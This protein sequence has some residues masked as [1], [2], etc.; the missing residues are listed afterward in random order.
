[1]HSRKSRHKL[2][3]QTSD[4]RPLS[5][6]PKTMK[7]TVYQVIVGGI[8]DFESLEYQEAKNWIKYLKTMGYEYKFTTRGR[9]ESEY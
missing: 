4:K 7:N 3:V 9:D 5:L 2:R 1:M 8:I 6:K